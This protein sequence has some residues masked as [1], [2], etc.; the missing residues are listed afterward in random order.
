[1]AG[2]DDNR[3]QGDGL[4]LLHTDRLQKH[5]HQ[6][7][8]TCLATGNYKLGFDCVPTWLDTAKKHLSRSMKTRCIVD[9]RGIGN[10]F[11]H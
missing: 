1:M 9:V 3:P 4:L 11:Q 7:Q 6:P 8:A 10:N 2:Q 5:I